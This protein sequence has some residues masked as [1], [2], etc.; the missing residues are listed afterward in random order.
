[1][2]C[3]FAMVKNFKNPSSYIPKQICL[4]FFS[5]FIFSNYILLIMLLQLSWFFPHGPPP[6]STPYSLRQSPHH[7]SCPWVMH[8]SS[9][10]TPFPTLYFISPWLSCN[11]IFI[12]LNPLTSSSSPYNTLL[13]G[14]HQNTLHIQVS[15]LSV[16]LVCFLDSIVDRYVFLPFYCSLFWS[17]FLNKTL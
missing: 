6:P 17:F 16:C 10:A 4:P 11:Y 15:V 5:F 2:L 3:Q 7:C 8:I 9:L 13:S 14:N 12:L 1:M